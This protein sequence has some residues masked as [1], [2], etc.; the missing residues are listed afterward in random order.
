M[1]SPF[2]G[3]QQPGCDGLVGDQRVDPVRVPHREVQADDGAEAAS[4]HGGRF[5][6]HRREQECR[7]VRVLGERRPA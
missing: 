2:G 4:E 3:G 5:G 7:V 6:C 1:V